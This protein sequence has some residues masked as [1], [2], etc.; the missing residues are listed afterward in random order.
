MHISDVMSNNVTIADPKQSI[1][2]A[3]KTMAELDAGSLPVGEGEQLVGMITDRDIAIRAVASGM[4][5]DTTID[6]I[7][8][9]E[10]KYC[11]E[12]DELEQIAANMAENKLRRLPVV[13]KQK[14][15]VG[16]VSLGDISHALGAQCG[17]ALADITMPGGR[18]SQHTD[19][20]ARPV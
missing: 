11:F 18:H 16:I 8:T 2:D 10:V 9:H 20:G 15:L 1:Q 6:K 4:S 19:G 7:M 14:R 5:L 12:D 13:N 3:A 17:L